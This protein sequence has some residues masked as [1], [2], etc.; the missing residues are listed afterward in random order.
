MTRGLSAVEKTTAG[1]ALAG[2]RGRVPTEAAPLG[3]ADV[4]GRGARRRGGGGGRK[5]SRPRRRGRSRFRGKADRLFSPRRRAVY[6]RCET[7]ARVPACP[8]PRRLPYDLACVGGAEPYLARV[9]VLAEVVELLR[10]RVL[11][12]AGNRGSDKRR[13]MHNGCRA[14]TVRITY[15][16]WVPSSDDVSSSLARPV[17][18]PLTTKRRSRRASRRIYRR[19]ESIN[20]ARSTARS[21]CRRVE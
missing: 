19:V 8:G 4:A 20:R 14:V 15:N 16:S 3:P 12:A 9:A 21:P 5:Q 6:P 17:I 7:R 11:P 1:P 13:V 10:V 2:D 18:I